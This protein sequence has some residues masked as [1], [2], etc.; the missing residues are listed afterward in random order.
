MFSSS[1]SFYACINVSVI[2]CSFML[3]QCLGYTFMTC[4]VFKDKTVYSEGL[5]S[6]WR[7][8]KEDLLNSVRE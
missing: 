6:I 3:L 4:I 7:Q 2:V 1:A 5:G 8:T